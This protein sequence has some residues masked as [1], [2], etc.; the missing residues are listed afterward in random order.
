MSVRQS[1]EGPH[2]R[3]PNHH[4]L[5]L[6]ITR[7]RSI[8]RLRPLNQGDVTVL[9]SYRQ[10]FNISVNLN[11]MISSIFFVSSSHTSFFLFFFWL[12][13]QIQTKFI[14]LFRG[15]EGKWWKSY[16]TF[17]INKRFPLRSMEN[18]DSADIWLMPEVSMTTKQTC[19]LKKRDNLNEQSLCWHRR[20]IILRN[21][22]W[23]NK[24]QTHDDTDWS[25]QQLWKLEPALI[26]NG[27][28]KRVM[29]R[30]H[31]SPKVRPKSHTSVLI[32]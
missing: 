16:L 29:Q 8:K 10:L 22:W 14:C 32:A 28:H 26:S 11:Q 25:R 13:N 9:W 17:S 12:S 7:C 18:T 19:W 21:V 1:G 23:G 4:L 3:L 2:L 5:C 6:L 15:S 20:L 30:Y 24:V 31:L 27:E